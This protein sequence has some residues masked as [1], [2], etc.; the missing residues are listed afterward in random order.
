M[1]PKCYGAIKLRIIVIAYCGREAADIEISTELSI[2][3][4]EFFRCEVA[5]RC[6][7]VI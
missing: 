7:D 4:F 5:A 1:G 3:S 6:C 2:V